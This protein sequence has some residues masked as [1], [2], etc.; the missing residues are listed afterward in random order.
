MQRLNI[1]TSNQEGTMR[2]VAVFD[3]RAPGGAA[4]VVKVRYCRD[5]EEYVCQVTDG[6]KRREWVDYF[7]SDKADALATGA[8]MAGLRAPQGRPEP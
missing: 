6:G 1:A 4:R 7:T 5:F 8:E 3:G 2:T